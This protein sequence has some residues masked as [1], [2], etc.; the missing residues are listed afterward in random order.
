MKFSPDFLALILLLL[1][2]TLIFILRSRF[3]GE[4]SADARDRK[5]RETF[6]RQE[7]WEP[8]K[9]TLP[10]TGLSQEASIF[11]KTSF[12]PLAIQQLLQNKLD[13]VDEK[14]EPLEMNLMRAEPGAI[15]AYGEDRMFRLQWAAGVIIVLT[16]L[17]SLLIWLLSFF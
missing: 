3:S 15:P 8:T 11:G 7:K 16:G 17:A 10:I 5:R 1:I 13:G 2:G 4:I 6:F 9:L 14:G 12:L